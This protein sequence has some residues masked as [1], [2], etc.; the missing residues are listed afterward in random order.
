ML[1]EWSTIRRSMAISSKPTLTGITS[2]LPVIHQVS[3]ANHR[4]QRDK[5]NGKNYSKLCTVVLKRNGS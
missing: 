1:G 2:G 4:V 5:G 3:V